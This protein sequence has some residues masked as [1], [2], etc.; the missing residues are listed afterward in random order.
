MSQ[1]HNA[2]A[3]RYAKALFNLAKSQD[4]LDVVAKNLELINNTATS[5][6]LLTKA[7]A[8]PTVSR[9]SLKNVVSA[10]SKKLSMDAITQNFL[11]LLAHSRRIAIID[12]AVD[13]YLRLLREHHGQL[14]ATVV[15][16]TPLD[17]KKASAI[18]NKLSKALGKTVKVKTEEK[19]SILGGAVIQM[20]SKMLDA[21]LAEKLKRIEVMSKKAIA[22]I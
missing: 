14:L 19:Q 21:S 10:L 18:E 13:A 17:A 5:N 16:A 8:S 9:E 1:S 22:S 20:G 4:K 6:P 2:I 3:R 7:F 12:V 15:T 11:L